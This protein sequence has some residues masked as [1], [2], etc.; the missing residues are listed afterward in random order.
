MGV[1]N[2]NKCSERPS[3]KPQSNVVKRKSQSKNKTNINK[4]H[5]SLD[6]PHGKC[7][8]FSFEKRGRKVRSN[9]PLYW[10]I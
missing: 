9:A 10:Y 3:T 5:K 6:E 4:L 1:T 7:H 8:G 2:P